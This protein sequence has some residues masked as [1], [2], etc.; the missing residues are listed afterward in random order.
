MFGY[1]FR[2][3]LDGI[4]RLLR[5]TTLEEH[6]A[7]L[8]ELRS[9]AS[10]LDAI[11]R[12]AESEA[13]ARS[14][15]GRRLVAGIEGR[16]REN[17]D[18]LVARITG[19]SM[20]DAEMIFPGLKGFLEMIRDSNLDRW[21]VLEYEGL[22]RSLR[23][24]EYFRSIR[25]GRLAVPRLDTRHPLAVSSNRHEVPSRQQERQLDLR[26]LQPQALSIPRRAAADA[27]PRP[28]LRG[29][30]VVR[31]L[32]DD[33]HFAVGDSTAA[34]IRCSISRASGPRSRCTCTPATSPSPSGSTTG[35]RASRSAS[36]P[37]PPGR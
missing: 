26:P 8:G 24:Q 7:V 14:E 21:K 31:S 5:V 22:L 9:L 20:P 29:G 15:A 11:S 16:F 18:R 25:E 13:V 35:R 27:G 30:R 37:S 28:R 3:A 17:E 34:T 10:R 6:E 36:R 33:G 12:L 4:R 32:I 1:R 19:L 2:Q 23:R